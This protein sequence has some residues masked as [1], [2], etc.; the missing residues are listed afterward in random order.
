MTSE[1]RANKQT[2][3]VGL[4]TVE[5]TNTGIIVSGIVTANSFSGPISGTTGIFSGDVDINGDL[6]VDGHTNLDNVSVAGV[7]TF[8]QKINLSDNFIR[9]CRGFNTGNEQARIVV[10]AGDNSAGGGLRIV[11]YHNDDTTLFSSEIANFYTNGIEL[12]ENVSVTGSGSFTKTS[13]NYI[14]V[15][16]SNAGGAS[17]VLDGDSNG[18]GSGTDYA[19]IE[20][21]SSGD[22][23]IVGDNPANAAN[24]IF[25]INSSAE[26]LRIDSNGFLGI[27]NASP[28]SS[29]ASARNLVIGTASGTH[30]MTIMSG[31]NNSGHIEFSDGTSSDA[32]KTAGGIRYYHDSDYMRFNTGGGSERLRITSDGKIGINATNPQSM[33]E[34]GVSTTTQSETD[35]RIAIFRKNGTAV[36]DEGYIHLTTMTGHYGIKLGYRNEGA[37]PTY[38]NQG[39]FISTVNGAENITNHVKRLVIQSDGKV[40]IGDGNS[41]TPSR[42]LDVRGTGQQQ[43][44]IGS[45]NNQ[46]ASLMLD[47]HGG[48]DGSGGNYGT[49]EMGSDGNFDIRNYD[50][51]KSIIFGTGSN[52]GANDRLTITS[53]GAL[54][55]TPTSG[56]SYFNSTSEYIFGSATSSPPSGGSEANVQIHAHKTRAQFSINAYMN[57]AGGPFMQF[58]TSRSGTVGTLGTKVQSNDYLGEIRFLGDNGTNYNSLAHGA[59]IYAKAKSTPA[60]GDTVIHGELNFAVGTTDG[61]DGV[62]DRLTIQESGRIK[63]HEDPVQRNSTVDNFTGDG[64]YMQHY[65]AR[66]G[67]QYRRNLDIASVGDGSWGSSI[68]FSTNSDSNATTSEAMRINHNQEVKIGGTYSDTT[69]RFLV[70]N[71]TA[72]FKSRVYVRDSMSFMSTPFGA[73]VTYDTGISVNASGYGGSMLCLCSR[74]YGAGTNTQ[75]ALY[76]L[77]FH[78]DGNHTPGVYYITGTANFA[79]FGQSGSN[80]LTVAMGASNNMFTVIESSV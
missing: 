4:G 28:V 79:S 25:K 63:F 21:D 47:G 67:A 54:Q 23:N 14:L 34:V 8:A 6:D 30:G 65:V 29:H 2:N 74:N 35:K 52:T 27:D 40:L 44:L 60:D 48:G 50:P 78:Y 17:L 72:A 3:R 16:S 70:D 26:K 1:I 15:G 49:M 61:T 45:T 13:N 42:N 56:P 38:L 11:E 75:S 20:H 55:H 58:V 80:T 39:F 66:T 22:L 36:G 41:I 43:I 62:K 31:T 68:R 5:Y 57:N 37:S 46:G 12:K 33:F 32:E 53:T 19:Y 7:T 71:G 10:K 59:T 51:A 64:A 69:H 77:K 24:I 76:F 18:D 9:N 73:N